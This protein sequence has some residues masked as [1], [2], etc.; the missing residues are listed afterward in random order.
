MRNIAVLYHDRYIEKILKAKDNNELFKDLEVAKDWYIKSFNLGDGQSAY[1]LGLLYEKNYGDM[2]EAEKWFGEGA[3]LNNLY[4]K[5]KFGRTLV[6]KKDIDG[7]V[8]MLN[9]TAEK[10][11]VMGQTFLGE[12]NENLKDYEKAVKYYSDAAQKNRGFYSH[13]AQYRLKELDAND[14]IPD[15]KNIEDIKELY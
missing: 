11:L 15:G 9:E 2:N 12:F 14:D 4:A 3:K 1:H 10:G 8:Q 5:A 13:V 6:D 7:G